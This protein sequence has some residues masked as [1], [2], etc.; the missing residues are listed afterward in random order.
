MKT[1]KLLTLLGASA[2]TVTLLS[3]CGDDPVEEEPPV[4][5]TPTQD[6][7]T[8]PPAVNEPPATEDG[9]QEDPEMAP[10]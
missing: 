3:A 8:P 1:K 2:L 6:E 10:E 9:M 4:D 5:N 7:E